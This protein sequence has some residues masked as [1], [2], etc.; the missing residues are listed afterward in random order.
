MD[1]G[2]EAFTEL[3]A[4]EMVVL[5][6]T[7]AHLEPDGVTWRLARHLNFLPGQAEFTG[8]LRVQRIPLGG[9]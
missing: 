7:F 3:A 4:D 6:P 5:Y 1:L 2:D 9:P 8:S